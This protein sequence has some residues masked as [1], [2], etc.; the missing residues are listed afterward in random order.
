MTSK[1][2]VRPSTQP[3]I[4]MWPIAKMT[5]TIIELVDAWQRVRAQLPEA[6][7]VLIG[8]REEEDPIP[9]TTAEVVAAP[10]ACELLPHCI[11]RRHP[12][13]DTSTPKTVAWAIPIQKTKFAI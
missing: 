2:A 11:P 7:L 12:A 1:S 6:R 8:P 10:T 9:V 3:P 4:D 5:P 13:M